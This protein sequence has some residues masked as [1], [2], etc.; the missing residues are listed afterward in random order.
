METH[1][2]AVS[3]AKQFGITCK[4]FPGKNVEIREGFY[5]RNV[6]KCGIETS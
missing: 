2:L 3:S 5:L 6:Q 4:I 1:L